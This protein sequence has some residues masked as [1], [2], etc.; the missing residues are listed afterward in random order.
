MKEDDIIDAYLRGEVD[1]SLINQSNCRK[2]AMRMN[3][4]MEARGAAM[5]FPNMNKLFEG[6][7]AAKLDLL[8]A[9]LKKGEVAKDVETHMEVEK[10]HENLEDEEEQLLTIEGMRKA[11][12]SEQPGFAQA[13][14]FSLRVSFCM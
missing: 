7:T 14:S 12:V 3:R 9:W 10:E 1:P 11:G 8:R 6:G 5:T 4:L 2:A 13:A